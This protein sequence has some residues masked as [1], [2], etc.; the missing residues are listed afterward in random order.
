MTFDLNLLR[1]LLALYEE[2]SV[3]RAAL[4]LEISQPAVSVALNKLR[5]ALG[6]PLFVRTSKGME[7]TPRAISLIDP[8]KDIL[9]RANTDFLSSAPFNPALAARTFT[10]ALT[11]VG[12]MVFL[13]KLL[14]RI[15]KEAPGSSVRSVALGSS[16]MARALEGGEVDLAIGYFPG[17]INRNLFQQRLCS[18]PFVCMLNTAHPVKQRSISLEQFLHF[19]HAAVRMEGKHQEIVDQVLAKNKLERNIVLLVSHFMAIPFI[20][21]STDLIATVPCSIGESFARMPNI[22]L[23]EPLFEIP[24]VDIKQ[25]WHRKYDKDGASLWLRS[26]TAEMFVDRNPA[27]DSS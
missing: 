6:D 2:G 23:A 3:S 8:T 10:F 5:A 22:K 18:P 21:A 1:I 27:K 13:P 26:M 16:E 19:D 25:Y 12:E 24:R 20:V 11:D 14:D 15:R 4:K 7:P 17:L 9:R